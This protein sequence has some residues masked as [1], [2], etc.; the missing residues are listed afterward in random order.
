MMPGLCR[1]MN[2]LVL[3]LV[4]TG[5][6]ARAENVPEKSAVDSLP[7]AVKRPLHDAAAGS[8]MLVIGEIHG[9]Q[10]TPAVAA[11]L[12]TP[13]SQLGY[14]VLALEIP[15]DQRE[16]VLAWAKGTMT[17]VPSFFAALPGDG[18]GNIELLTLIRTAVSPPFRW[19]LICFDESWGTGATDPPSKAPT[20]AELIALSVRRDTTMASNLCDQYQRQNTNAKVLAICGN[21]HARIANHASSDDL[22]NSA[23]LLVRRVLKS[24]KSP[25]GSSVP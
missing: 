5:T 4:V 18:R 22:L 11:A 15:A 25:I 17:V 10:E 3:F 20:E 8:D 19:Q 23:L 7:D 24:K 1:I 6:S 13:L 2:I 21:L 14:R 16:P 9:T 12:L